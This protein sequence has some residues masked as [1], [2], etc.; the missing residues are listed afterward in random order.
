MEESLRTT[1]G[2]EA[3]QDRFRVTGILGA[4]LGTLAL[5]SEIFIIN[6][7]YLGGIYD[8]WSSAGG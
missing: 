3:W 5:A 8:T 6:A 7:T 4:H 1:V 2:L